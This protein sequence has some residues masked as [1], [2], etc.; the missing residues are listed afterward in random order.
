MIPSEDSI[1]A[2]T[3]EIFETMIMMDVT[4]GK[5]LTDKVN[6]FTESV[7]GIVGL[8]GICKGMLAIH[9][10]ND[11]AK[12]ITTNFLGMEVEEIDEDVKDAIGELANMLAGNIKTIISENG[13]DITLSVPSAVCGEEYTVDCLADA[14]WITVPFT[15]PEGKFLVSIEIEKAV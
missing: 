7:S 4:P 5:Q 14:E 12:T 13:K 1:V 10:P 3:K 15:V 9:T 8:A 11:V 6:A 2:A